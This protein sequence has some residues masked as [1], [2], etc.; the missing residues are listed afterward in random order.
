MECS[1]LKL[2]SDVGLEI[3]RRFTKAG[4][5]DEDSLRVAAT[6][7]WASIITALAL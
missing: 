3:V 2:W 6:M 5:V 4:T 1:Q 7:V